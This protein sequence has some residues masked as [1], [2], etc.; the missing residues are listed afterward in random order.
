MAQQDMTAKVARLAQTRDKQITD[1]FEGRHWRVCREI[2]GN[3][4][5]A[6][7]RVGFFRGYFTITPPAVFQTPQGRR[8]RA[9]YLMQETDMFGRDLPGTDPLPFGR[10]A[11]ETANRRFPGAVT[12]LPKTD[13][14][15]KGVSWLP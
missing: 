13:P 3:R 8:G 4:E 7:H 14:R 6:G 10:Q 15:R 11:L 5:L 12:S 9:G 1:W 2:T